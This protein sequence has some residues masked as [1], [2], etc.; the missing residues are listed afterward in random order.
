MNKLLPLLFLFTCLSCNNHDSS[1][2]KENESKSPNES[3][4]PA[5]SRDS[6]DYTQ[7]YDPSK[8]EGQQASSSQVQSKRKVYN[9]VF[10]LCTVKEIDKVTT[11]YSQYYNLEKPGLVEMQLSIN[12]LQ[13]C[14]KKEIT[15][16]YSMQGGSVQDVNVGVQK[17]SSQKEAEDWYSHYI[18]SMKA[19]PYN[20]ECTD[21]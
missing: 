15:R 19:Y 2:T 6:V 8:S 10:F 21:L 20:S 4:Q 7:R 1:Q 11:Y 3:N 12:R 18:K 16:T 14:L 5:V 17:F 13:D 9:C